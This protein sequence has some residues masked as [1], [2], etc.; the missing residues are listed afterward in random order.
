VAAETLF[1]AEEVEVGWATD[2]VV[3]TATLDVVT[4]LDGVDDEPQAAATSAITARRAPSSLGG[5]D[6]AFRR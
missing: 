5:G 3:R 6:E 1:A 4:A 2:V